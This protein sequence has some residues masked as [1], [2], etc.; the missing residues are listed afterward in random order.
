MENNKG[1][2]KH[3]DTS[4][5]PTSTFDL[6][7][8]QSVRATFRL[9]AETIDAISIIS[10]HLGIK[11]KS[12]FDHLLEDVELLAELARA[13][14]HRDKKGSGGIQKTYVVSRR[15]LYA[16][17]EISSN[18]NTPRDALIEYSVQR[19]LPIIA[20][21]REK[22]LKRKK[23]LDDLKEH[24]SDGKKILN[25]IKKSLGEDDMVYDKFD[26]AM[27]VYENA[28]DSILSF[29]EKGKLI[30]NFVPEKME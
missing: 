23:I 4:M 14:E 19:L 5:P 15:S 28:Y 11:Q 7:G 30:E 25:S 6:R 17:D 29:V 8:K 1:N 20:K 26:M 10:S 3:P 27:T 16:L 22:H 9:S 2:E 18:F 12:V 24:F 21:E 13:F